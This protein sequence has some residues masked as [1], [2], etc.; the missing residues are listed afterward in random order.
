MVVIEGD[1]VGRM[2]LSGPGA[3]EGPTAS[4]ILGDIIDIARG[5]RVP[6]FGR[7]AASLAAPRRQGPGGAPPTICASR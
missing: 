4:A 6:A 3:G 2:V 7:P 1:F 5:P